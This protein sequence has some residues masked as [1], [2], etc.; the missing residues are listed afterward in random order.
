MAQNQKWSAQNYARNASFVPA[1]GRDLLDVLAAKR[2][3]TILDLGCGDGELTR[4]IARDCAKVIGVDFSEEMLTKTRQ[5]G[6]ETCHMDGQKL[7]FTNVFDAVFTNA[8]LHWMPDYRAV[9][10]GVHDAL[11]PGGRFVGELGGY[12]NIAAIITA[13]TDILEEIDLDGKAR[14]PWFFP[15]P[16]F[17][18][19]AL[20]SHGF[21]VHEISLTPRPTLLPNGIE[22]WLST[23]GAPFLYDLDADMRK[24]LLARLANALAGQ[25]CDPQGRWLADYVRLRFSCL[26]A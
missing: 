14:N 17:Y 12:G 20:Q 7:S 21:I 13:L 3:E 10:R 5:Y 2:H 19:D 1:Y 23:F 22:G 9:L 6:L 25:L 4:H 16:D 24:K 15:K 18:R 8:A 26:R 11:K